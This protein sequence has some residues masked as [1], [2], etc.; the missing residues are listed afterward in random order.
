MSSLAV[1]EGK[2]ARRSLRPSR[3]QLHEVRELLLPIAALAGVFIWTMSVQGNALSYE[4]LNLLFESA[5]PIVFAT[6]A[7][8]VI[9]SLG[10]IDLSVGYFIGLANVIIAVYLVQQPGLGVLCL[11]GLVLAFVVLS[12]LISVRKVPSI[13]ATLGASFIWLGVGRLILPTPGGAAPTWLSS[14][15]TLNPP[16]FPLPIWLIA[17]GGVAAYLILFRTRIGILIRGAGSNFDALAATGQSRIK[18]R[19]LAYAVAAVFAILAGFAVTAVTASGDPTASSDYTLFSIAGVILGGGS[20]QGGRA[21]TVGMVAGALVISLIGSLLGLLNVSSSLQV[22]AQ[23]L[24]LLAVIAG[25][26]FWS[27]RGR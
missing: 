9:I 12:V 26:R 5:V 20:F 14:F 2:T 1:S 21:S 24:V 8:G 3:F 27:E 19:A 10:D 18:V 7:Q 13:I 6:I 17:G 22:G 11:I 16:L 15:F 25:R 23:G 4:G